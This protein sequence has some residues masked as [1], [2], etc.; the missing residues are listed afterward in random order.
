[1]EDPSH[2]YSFA[3]LA[4]CF[5]LS[6]FFSCSET[7]LL[8]VSKIR[9][10]TL[11]EEGNHKAKIV[12]RLINDTDSLLSTILVGNNLV[13]I[14]ASS[15]STVLAVE[16][17]GDAGAGIAT[18]FVTLVI[19]IF[20]EIT[21]KS[22]AAKYA[23]SISMA[24]ARPVSFFVFVLKP[25]V[26]ILNFITG[27]IMKLLGGERQIGPTLTEEELKTYVTVS[28]EEG[29]I[30]E[31]EKE[32]IHN[33]FEFGDTEIKEIM[34]PRIH[35]VSIPDDVT[36]DELLDIYKEQRFSRIPVHDHEDN[37]DI[38]G[39]LNVKDLVLAT[40]D[41]D[42]F[43]VREYAREPFVVYEF[44]HIS[45]V[46]ER[47][48]SNKKSSLAVVLDEYG[49]MSGIVTIEDMIEEIV[50][51][52]DDEY[53]EEEET[54][55][56]IGENTYLIDGSVSFNEI[57]DVLGTHFE[58]DDFESIGGLVLGEIGE[59]ELH[60][61]LKIGRAALSVEKIH[62]NRIEQLKMVL[63]DSSD[64]DSQHPEEDKD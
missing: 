64:D 51:D 59:P 44:N 55:K 60:R 18:G 11:A 1:M 9:M 23:D 37:D 38:I 33:V 25:V 63:E 62:K 30:E 22:M 56:Q 17:F 10:R 52:I 58:S 45:D 46:F 35:V 36:Y 54:I 57:N 53:D 48:R 29:I 15:L 50:G 14:G 19:L 42:N 20:G 31:D 27:F 3:V 16:L 24:I 49:I 12:E 34:T 13:N 28:H 21:P 43:N 8:S 5:I 32:M 4:V 26:V 61:E 6:G 47:M 40:I 2:I 41:R 39:V 7:A